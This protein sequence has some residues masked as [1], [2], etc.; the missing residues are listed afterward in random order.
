MSGDELVDVVDE[1]DRVVTQATRREV[2]L[3]NLRHRS[4]YV[5]VFNS[6]G[7]LFVHRRTPT[8]DVFPDHWDVAAGGVLSASETYDQAAARELREE[9]GI[10]KVPLRRLFAL[11]YD[12]EHTRVAG[13]VYSCTWDGALRLQPSEVAAGEWIDLDVLVER[14]Q[15]ERF[16]PDGI[17]ALRRYLAMLQELRDRK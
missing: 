14:M 6:G 10:A 7:Q 9:L 12:D 15:H 17:E 3:R 5:L 2:R 13:V 16:C 4:V 8:K 1:Q 11:R